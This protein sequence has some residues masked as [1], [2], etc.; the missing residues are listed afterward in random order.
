MIC[1]DKIECP[2][3]NQLAIE[4]SD[5]FDKYYK[6]DDLLYFKCKSCKTTLG[7]TITPYGEV[8]IIV[9]EKSKEEK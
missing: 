1:Q 9:W 6:A 2:A 8:R 3:C 4:K 7:S 5:W